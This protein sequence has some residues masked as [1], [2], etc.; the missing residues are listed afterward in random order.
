MN[1]YF[2]IYKLFGAVFDKLQNV[3]RKSKAGKKK[4]SRK[5]KKGRAS[6]TAASPA[7]QATQ[8]PAQARGDV[9]MTSPAS[10]AAAAATRTPAA[11]RGE[12]GRAAGHAVRA[13]T[14]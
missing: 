4:K 9:R 8:L 2:D 11:K 12:P 10:G 7:Q 13:S 1:D 14:R 6:R 5:R 3:L